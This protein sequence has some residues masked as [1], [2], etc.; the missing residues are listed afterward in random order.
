MT[1]YG[2][3]VFFALFLVIVI[4]TWVAAPPPALAHP[5]GNFTINHYS[6]LQVSANAVRLRYVLDMAE[7]PT[8]QEKQLID[9]NGDGSISADEQAKYLNSKLEALA[10]NLKLQ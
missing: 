10:H 2:G 6:R 1:G 7:I 3:W 4:T 8:F 5:L 9:R